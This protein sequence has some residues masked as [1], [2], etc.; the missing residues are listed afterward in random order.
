MKHA[1]EKSEAKYDI[2]LKAKELAGYTL[3]ITSNEKHFPKRYRL[4]VTNKMQEMSVN[5]V[6]WLIMANEIYPETKQE[7][8]ERTLLQKK[9]R[10]ECRAML[11]MMEI[12]A[13]TFSIRPETLRE[14]TD[15]T[16]KLKNQTTR[17]ILADK[18]RFKKI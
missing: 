7:R 15:K 10:A 17:W 13:D 16:T 11:T 3:R 14:W 12:A 4:T 9:A 6:N 5:I 2:L 8:E 18:E 1:R